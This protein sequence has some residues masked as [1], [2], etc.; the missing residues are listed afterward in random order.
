M[1]LGRAVQVMRT[2]RGLTQVELAAAA[3]I[4]RVVVWQI[5]S[6]QMFPG[7]EVESGI[8]AALRWPAQA[9]VAFA[10]LE[11]EAAT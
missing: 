11:G 10:I 3:G 5:E 7:P 2:V 1:E 6:G 4:N 8:K 9:D